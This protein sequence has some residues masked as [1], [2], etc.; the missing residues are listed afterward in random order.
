MGEAPQARPGLEDAV[1]HARVDEAIGQDEIALPR[2]AAE[3]RG[4]GGVAG[5]E[6]QRLFVPLPFGQGPLELLVKFGVTGDERRGGRRGAPGLES[7]GG[8]G[9]HG[10][11]ARQP[12]VIVVG[13]V[14]APV[15]RGARDKP[16]AQGG[17]LALH[18]R[19]PQALQERRV[20]RGRKWKRTD[21]GPRPDSPSSGMPAAASPARLLAATSFD[22]FFGALSQTPTGPS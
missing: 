12:E 2:Q 4:I 13:E 5:V 18:Q 14:D 7:G 8:G 9:D 11:V 6:D 21:F 19:L 15:V 10:G 20:H 1:Q 16:A 22:G 3:H 17:A